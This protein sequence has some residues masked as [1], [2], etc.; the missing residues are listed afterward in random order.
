VGSEPP[1]RQSLLARQ[2]ATACPGCFQELPPLGDAAAWRILCI[3]NNAVPNH[4]I[5]VRLS[6]SQYRHKKNVAHLHDFLEDWVTG[7]LGWSQHWQKMKF[8]YATELQ[9][10][11]SDVMG[12]V[13]EVEVRMGNLATRNVW[14]DSVD[15]LMGRR[16][17]VHEG[18]CS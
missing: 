7:I 8:A 3:G 4:G 18:R 14:S 12:H 9:N 11:W 5:T 2:C 6:W 13:Q 15:H 1:D 17:S 16:C 10:V